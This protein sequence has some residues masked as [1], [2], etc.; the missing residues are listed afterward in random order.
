MG[1]HMLKAQSKRRRTKQQVDI[2]KQ[3]ADEKEVEIQRKIA[4]V[5]RLRAE[6]NALAEEVDNNK[7]A[8]IQ[9]TGLISK[10]HV[11]QDKEGNCHVPVAEESEQMNQLQM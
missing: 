10:G 1:A 2:D 7:G 6:R 11:V 8:Y 4:E 3:A 9:L 5:N